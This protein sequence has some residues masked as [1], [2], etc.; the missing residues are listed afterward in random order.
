MQSFNEISNMAEDIRQ[1]SISQIKTKLRKKLDAKNIKA[2]P[3]VDSEINN[4]TI[5]RYLKA[6][7][8]NQ[9]TAVK[10]MV[11]TIEWK[12]KVNPK[13]IT[14]HNIEETLKLGIV[15]INGFNRK[16]EPIIHVAL[17]NLPKHVTAALTTETLTN[18][19]VFMM[20]T[21]IRIMDNGVDKAMVLIHLT[22]SSLSMATLFKLKTAFKTIYLHYPE[23]ISTVFVI[24]PS[25][26]V[27]GAI[28]SFGVF[29][30]PSIKNKIFILGSTMH[31]DT[32]LPVLR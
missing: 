22:N 4:D 26:L 2:S 19:M 27:K 16:S 5:V 28:K 3:E 13:S 12:Q 29:L 30:S 14:L 32:K 20:E 24:N 21:A 1:V 15:Y 10:N 31:K 17:N 9:D 18:I 11:K 23:R 8:W 25:S 6:N 7:N